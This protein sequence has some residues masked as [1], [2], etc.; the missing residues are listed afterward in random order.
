MMI[1]IYEIKE[2]KSTKQD[3]EAAIADQLISV[4]EMN[5]SHS[6]HEVYGAD[7]H[8]GHASAPG[9]PNPSPAAPPPAPAYA[10]PYFVQFGGGTR[11]WSTGLCHCCD[12]AANCLITCCCPCITFGQIAEIVSKGSSNC[13]VSG[14][15]YA[16]LCLTGLACLY[17]C[18]YRSRMRAQYDLEDA[19]C[20]DCLVHVFCEGCSLCQEYRELKNRGFDMGIG[21]EANV[22]RQRRGIT[23]PPVVAQGMTR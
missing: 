8:V 17:S 19:P 2:Q 16:L 12:D 23:L 9:F 15:L 10:A 14:A 3:L 5:H 18:A 6:E 11:R 7:R 4:A 22:D 20:V 21:W 1:L 13:A